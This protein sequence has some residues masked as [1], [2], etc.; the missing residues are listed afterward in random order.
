MVPAVISA[1]IFIGS[2]GLIFTERFNRVIVAL[3]G[4]C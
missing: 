3:L 2:L 4:E 1:I